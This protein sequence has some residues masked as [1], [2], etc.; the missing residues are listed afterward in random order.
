[1]PVDMNKLVDLDRLKE[2]KTTENNGIAP[3]ET[4]STASKAYKTGERFYFQGKLCIATNDIAQGGTITLNTNCKLDVLGDDVSQLLTA[5]NYNGLSN[6]NLIGSDG[7]VLY[8]V[9]IP[10][11]TV[12]TMSTAD[13]TAI[14][15]SGINLK[16]H[17]ADGNDLSNGGWNFNSSYTKRT[18]TTGNGG[19]TAYFV[20]WTSTPPKTLQLNYGSEVLPYEKYNFPINYLITCLQK[21]TYNKRNLAGLDSSVYYPVNVAKNT[22]IT[23]STADKEPLNQSELYLQFYDENYNYLSY[24]TFYTD[25]RFRTFTY[26]PETTAKYIKWNKD[27]IKPVQ[28]EIG[29]RTDYHPYS[30]QIGNPDI[31]KE[32]YK[33]SS[34]L[35]VSDVF[36]AEPYTGEYDW[37]TPVVS[38]GSLFKGLSSVESFA[39][40]TDSH[41][42]G[43]GDSSRNETN[44]KNYFKRVQKTYNATP[45]SFMVCGGDLLNNSTTMDEACYRLGYLKGINDH[46]LDGCKFVVGNHDTNYQG[47]LD[48][49]SENGTGRLTDATIASIMYRNTDT[50]KAYY[51]FDGANS[52]CYVLDSG[53]EHSTML[54]YDWEQIAWL[55]GKLA[56]DDPTHAI[57]FLH[58][59]V[60]S[61]NVQTNASNFGTLVAAYNSHTTVTL[62]SVAYDFTSCTGH[63]DFW[64]AGHTHVDSN[65]TL[66]GIPYFVTASNGYN[67]DVPIIDLVLADYGNN[68]LY[69]K[70]VGG[71][72]S[73]RTISLTTGN[74]VT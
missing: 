45:C 51:S 17:D 46:L 43:F 10:T 52:K 16:F 66:G 60:N 50:K 26:T 59:I 21:E 54:D 33:V 68:L 37:Q 15:A 49:E 30:A 69:L 73:D 25:N 28:V 20:S 39:F 23:M 11:G 67:S 57:I 61:G 41:V 13:R 22:I 31:I 18:I 38:Y 2:Y 12:L 72:G 5:I 48:S 8:P 47:K 1:M 32:I 56:E 9:E 3:I 7:N 55:A 40:F 34:C 4:T 29:Y 63:V 65:G 36:N 71:T 42:M 64:V 27:P 58:I 14:G 6:S 19:Q 53:I 35:L 24:W 74:L 70:R 44:M 62:N